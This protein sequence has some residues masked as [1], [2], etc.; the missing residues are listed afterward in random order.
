MVPP[1][2]LKIEFLNGLIQAKTLGTID[3]FTLDGKN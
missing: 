1:N 2:Y 3:Y